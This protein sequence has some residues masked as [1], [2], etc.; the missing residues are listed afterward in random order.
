MVETVAPHS[1]HRIV[2]EVEALSVAR[3][4]SARLARGASERDKTR[5]IP[6]QE[7]DEL[8]ASGL[9]AL[10]VP[11]TLG[12]ADVSVQ[13][14]AQVFQ[15]LAA[16]DP[17]IAQLPQSHYVFL[18][19]LRQDGTPAQQAFFFEQVLAGARFGNAQAER[20]SASA[21]DLRTRLRAESSG[22]FRLNGTKHYCTGALTAHWIPVAAL[23]DDDRLVLAYVPRQA[24]GVEVL[25]DW[26]AMGQRITYSGTTHFRDVAVVA[27][28][29][30][31]H[32][33]L[34]ERPAVFHAFGQM[35]HAA[36]DVGVAQNALEDTISGIRGRRRP[37]LGAPPGNAG[38]DPLLLHRLGQLD[39]RFRAAQGLLIDSARLL[40]AAGP[41]PAEAAAAAAAVVVGQA[42]AYAEEVSVEIASELFALIG[43]SA[44]D[45]DLN[46][47]RHWRNARTHTVHDANQ[48][49]Y[50]AAGNWLINGIPPSK[51]VR[52]AAAD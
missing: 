26:N 27:K 47:H 40:D 39:A 13:T 22:K 43:T 44:A 19:A 28:W 25:A 29:V 4:V 8:S 46:Y 14:L 9:L 11:R 12:G 41:R 32:W 51:P 48:W 21:L 3:E 49:R 1:A 16:G 24:A 42:K 50:H 33:R 30:V 35:L 5:R 6:T 37:R 38:S 15:I 7:M 18:D 52:R 36:I 31:P 45:E 20:G 17:A 2:S 23:D 10:T 34:F